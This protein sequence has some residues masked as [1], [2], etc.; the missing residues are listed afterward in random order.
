[1][2]YLQYGLNISENVC[3]CVWVCEWVYGLRGADLY[4]VLSVILGPYK[5]SCGLSHAF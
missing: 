1:M 3:L 5:A 2:E 4:H